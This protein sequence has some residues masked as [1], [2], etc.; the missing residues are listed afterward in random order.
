MSSPQHVVLLDTDVISNFHTA[1]ELKWLVTFWR[2]K[3]VIAGEVL[4]EVKQWPGEGK[5]ATKILDE[6][7]QAGLLSTVHLE[8]R[9]FA[10]YVNFRQRLG[11]GEA[12]SIA[13]AIRRGYAVATD[14][15]GARR[16]CRRQNPPVEVYSTEDFLE[17][18]VAGG[19]FSR[20]DA[21]HIWKRMGIADP[22]RGIHQ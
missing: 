21:E 20:D 22:T 18:A 6:A 5:N 19:H 8:R 1:G 9:E 14:D 3:L 16:L 17:L 12:E 7:I 10:L 4:G 15:R 11:P 2:G 13:I